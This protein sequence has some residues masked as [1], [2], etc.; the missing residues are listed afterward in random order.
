MQS[1]LHFGTALTVTSIESLWTPWSAFNFCQLTVCLSIRSQ[2]TYLIKHMRKHSPDLVP[3]PPTAGQQSHSPAHGG[4]GG[5]GSAEGAAASRAERNAYQ[6]Q[7]GVPCV[8][9]LQ[10]YKPVTAPDV[11]YKTVSVSDLSS[12]KDLCITV[13]ASAIQVEHL[14]SWGRRGLW[15]EKSE[16]RLYK[17]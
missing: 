17:Q 8:F 9:D 10:Q 13:E 12:H 7:E 5:G 6:Q 11:S 16:H 1:H 4:A 15:E 3:T 2:E 14:S